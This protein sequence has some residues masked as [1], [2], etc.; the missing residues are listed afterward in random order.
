MVVNDLKKPSYIVCSVHG[1]MA[2]GISNLNEVMIMIHYE[3]NGN[4]IIIIWSNILHMA[5]IANYVHENNNTAYIISIIR[6]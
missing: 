6:N 2:G 5:E 4:H 1:C 3:T